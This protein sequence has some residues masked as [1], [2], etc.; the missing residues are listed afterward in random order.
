M[1]SAVAGLILLLPALVAA[2]TNP[3]ATASKSTVHELTVTFVTSALPTTI[4]GTA[5]AGAA[6]ATAVVPGID[7]GQLTQCAFGCLQKLPGELTTVLSSSQI[8]AICT[9]QASLATLKTCNQ[10]CPS[11]LLNT[12]VGECS[13]FPA[14]PSNVV[15]TR[16]PSS[17]AM[18]G[19]AMMLAAEGSWVKMLGGGWTGGVALGTAMVMGMIAM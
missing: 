5:T 19:R 6:Q 13:L 7:L 18:P 17:A 10:A 4:S 1:I 9:D 2:G 12:L 16:A 11:G 8:Q 3:A 14:P 15:T